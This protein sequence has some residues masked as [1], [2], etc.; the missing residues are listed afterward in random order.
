MAAVLSGG[1]GTCLS[2]RAAGSEWQLRWWSGRPSVTTPTWRRSSNALEVHCCS[3]SADEVTVL[4]GIPITTVPRT[5]LDLATI[6][7]PERLLGAINEAEVRRLYD[8]L[9][10]PAI[11]ERH[12]GERGTAR[13][14]TVLQDAGYGV[15]KRAL[16]ELFARFIV[17]RGL[18]RPELNGSIEVGGGFYSPDCLWRAQRL[19]VELHSAR[20][21]GTTP[22]ISRD[23]TRDRR[24]MLAGWSVIHVTWA[25]LHSRVESDALERDLRIVLRLAA[26]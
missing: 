3:L 12:R 16:E 8:P 4:D 22:A 19:I 18:P 23:A 17:E 25:Q 24:L 6:L 10:L 21:H 7:N 13:L 20:Y 5:L 1:A 11:L 9:S 15:T 2:H 14:R 26:A